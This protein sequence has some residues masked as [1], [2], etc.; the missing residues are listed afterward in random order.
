MVWMDV[1]LADVAD[2]D[3]LTGACDV[4]ERADLAGGKLVIVNRCA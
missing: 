2:L 3:D 1:G 4:D